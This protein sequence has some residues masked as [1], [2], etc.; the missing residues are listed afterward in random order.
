MRLAT[1]A[2]AALVLAL[3]TASADARPA[4][5]TPQ[6]IEDAVE[7][8][9]VEPARG[10]L[11]R[12]Y[13]IAAPDRL[14]PAYRSSTPWDGTTVLLELSRAVKKMP[15]GPTAREIEALVEPAV[16][17]STCSSSS[18]SLPNSTSTAHFYVEYG[19]I[20]VASGLDVADYTASLETAWTTEVDSFGWAAPPVAPSPA[21][22]SRYH[23]RIDALSPGLYGFVSPSGTH[24]GPVGNNPNTAWSDGDA[25]ASCMVLNRDYSGFDPSSPQAALDSTTAH[26]FNH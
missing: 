11:L 9:K 21:P 3:G 4:P 10:H 6:L 14:P 25:Y 15:P 1:A 24:A 26:E 17:G 12:A 16:A 20:A 13:A 7:R 23:V 2:A 22:G 19:T 8:G 5:S 18:S